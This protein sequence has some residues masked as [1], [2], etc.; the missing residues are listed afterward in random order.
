MG[1]D[2]CDALLCSAGHVIV[3]G[4]TCLRLRG[5]R[6]GIKRLRIPEGHLPAAFK[7]RL[8]GAS[9]HREHCL[10]H[11][12]QRHGKSIAEMREARECAAARRMTVPAAALLETARGRDGGGGEEQLEGL[13]EAPASARALSRRSGESGRICG[14]GRIGRGDAMSRNRAHCSGLGEARRYAAS[15]AVAHHAKNERA[16]EMEGHLREHYGRSRWAR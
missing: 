9:E 11:P 7:A 4:K 10:R 8:C 15:L 3:Q 5:A 12:A 1:T 2:G 6:E 13:V 14:H 16:I